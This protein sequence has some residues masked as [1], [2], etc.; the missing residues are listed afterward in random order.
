MNPDHFP[1]LKITTKKLFRV[2]KR[3]NRHNPRIQHEYQAIFIHIPKTAGTSITEELKKLPKKHE[4]LSPKLSKHAKAWEV[5]ALLGKELWDN[6][7]TFSF[8]RNPWDLMVS[9]YHWWL[10]KAV[11][12][13]QYSGHVKK[14]QNKGNFRE[15][16]R[17]KYGQKMINERYG[18]LYD[19]LADP[20]TGRRI[21]DY[22]GSVESLQEDWQH[23]C[24]RLGIEPGSVGQHNPT[25]RDDYREYYDD[26]SKDLV[27]QRFAR[28]IREFGYEF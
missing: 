26:K 28:S 12:M 25:R 13:K 23:I 16:L 10:Q 21:I 5:R 6:Y 9:S 19:W 18:D 8:V 4:N 14:I 3:V 15:F 2:H 7:F 17:S 1:T 11:N 24:R 20:K 27:A 22:V